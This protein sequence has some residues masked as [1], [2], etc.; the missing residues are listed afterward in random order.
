[1]TL[2][3]LQAPFPLRVGK[4]EAGFEISRKD[5]KNRKTISNS[6][7]KVRKILSLSFCLLSS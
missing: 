6:L 4:H 1:V 3:L 2:L 7:H 5:I